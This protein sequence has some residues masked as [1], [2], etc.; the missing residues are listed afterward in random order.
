MPFSLFVSYTRRKK[1]L[2]SMM[3]KDKNKHEGEK[4]LSNYKRQLAEKVAREKIDNASKAKQEMT[5]SR[6]L[7]D[8]R[9]QIFDSNEIPDPQVL[10]AILSR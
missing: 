2:D 8:Q 10:E 7:M 6:R 9:M 3:S 4:I 5:S 1:I